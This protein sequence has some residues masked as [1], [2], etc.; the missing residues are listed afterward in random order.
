MLR[1]ALGLG[2]NLGDR[3]RALQDALDAL[4]TRG[5]RVLAASS[6]YET[7]P[8]GEVL[9]QPS[10]LNACALV[11]TDLDP[12][13]LLAAC[14]AVELGAGRDRSAGAVRHGPRP[15][16]V[17]VLLLDGVVSAVPELVVPHPALLERRFV[18]IPLLELDAELVTPDGTRLADALLRLDPRV[19]V[20]RAGPPLG[21]A[22][23]AQAEGRAPS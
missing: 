14:Q 19:A 3:A 13:G 20:R 10:F 7:D 6:T 21:A 18:L 9:D 12:L 11:E 22:G 1:G 5:V 8:V 4:A 2:A 23:T 16:D 17:D 15:L